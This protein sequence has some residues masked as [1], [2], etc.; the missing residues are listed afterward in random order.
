MNSW[1]KL[2]YINHFNRLFKLAQTANIIA[3]QTIENAK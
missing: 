3:E 2:E 1:K